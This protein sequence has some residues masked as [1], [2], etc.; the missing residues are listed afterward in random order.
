MIEDIAS[1]QNLHMAF[2]KAYK[3]KKNDPEAAHFFLNLEE[4][5][6]DLK[7]ELLSKTYTPGRYRYFRI[8]FPKERIISVAPFKDRVVHHA[9]VRII[10][11]IFEKKF[12]ENSFACRKGKGTHRAVLLA[13][14]LLLYNSFYL[15]MDVEK[16]F[17]TLDHEKFIEIFSEE[18]DDAHVL[19][20][21]K[22]IF[23][24]SERSS[25][26]AG[27]G[28]PI[29]NLTSQFF[30][31]VYL[32]KLD[33]YIMDVCSVR[34]YI[35]YMDDMV[36]FSN[37]IYEL[38]DI[39]DKTKKFMKENLRVELKQRGTFIQR[40]ENGLSF[41]GYRIFPNLVRVKNKNIRRLKE[42]IFSRE[43]QYNIGEIKE[44][45]RTASVQSIIG[46]FK[47]ADS[48]NLMKSIFH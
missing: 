35:R 22:K 14:K 43:K 27:K 23:Q 26:V 32:D 18:I 38:K 39:R 7:K 19:W 1:F 17:E 21:V 47:H 33:H 3:G 12:V 5:L 40:Q 46:Y 25:G 9:L 41:I 28:I 24:T 11:P 37:D 44:E 31:N 15:K 34:N 42:K 13:Q 10:E 16:Y 2:Q 45:N 30:A 20:L 48:R 36:I 6:F 4:N 29:G 8:R